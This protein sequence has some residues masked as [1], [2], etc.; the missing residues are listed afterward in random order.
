MVP[1]TAKHESSMLQDLRAGKR[2]EIDAFNGA[3][4]KLGQHYRLEAPTN[5]IV[6]QIIK[7]LEVD[8]GA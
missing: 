5:V 7:F 3:I 4:V 2:T 8:K 1:L 6:S